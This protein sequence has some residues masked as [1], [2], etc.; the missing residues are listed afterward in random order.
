MNVC[1][2]SKEIGVLFILAATLSLLLLAN[3]PHGGEHLKNLL[4][5]QILWV[6]YEQ[7]IPA[8][9]IYAIL[10]FSW[11]VLKIG[12]KF[13]SAFY[14]VFAVAVSVQLV[15][16]YLVFTSLIIP[17]LVIR[18]LNGKKQLLYAFS[19]GAFSYALGL[20]ASAL[21]DLPSGAIIV[22]SLAMCGVVT[23]ILF[24]DK[25]TQN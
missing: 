5:G 18:K 15:G 20:T 24:N 10:L 17:A 8:A 19:F 12:D 21:F 11:F 25:T 14:L 4:V 9:C 1:S 6:S 22:W 13:P 23:S 2:L 16:V 7:L 3:N